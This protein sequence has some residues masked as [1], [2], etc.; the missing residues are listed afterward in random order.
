MAATSRPDL[1]DVALLRPGRIDKAVLCGFP[2]EQ[3]RT[4]I[5]KLYLKKFNFV[6]T[7]LFAAELA[8]Q[9]NNFTSADLK[10]LIQ[11]AQLSK[12]SELLKQAD[13]NFELTL[14]EHDI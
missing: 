13:E 8:N 9:T 2:D 12:M 4:D 5:I 7:D 6:G 10:G 1:V 11:T 14:T 3:D